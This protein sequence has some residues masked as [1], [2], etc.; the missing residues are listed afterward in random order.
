MT[1]T[2]KCDA[3]DCGKFAVAEPPRFGA[4]GVSFPQEWWVQ[5]SREKVI[6]GCCEAHFNAAL[7][8]R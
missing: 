3:P 6:V 1:V 7:K 2:A 4:V 5:T 8:A